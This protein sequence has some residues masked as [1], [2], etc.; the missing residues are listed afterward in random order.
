M[1]VK[2]GAAGASAVSDGCG[3]GNSDV[4]DCACGIAL[5]I[6]VSTIDGVL[7]VE[8]KSIVS[9]VS[10]VAIAMLV[11]TLS[12]ALESVTIAD[13]SSLGVA[14]VD[15]FISESATSLLDAKL[16]GKSAVVR[17]PIELVVRL[18]VPVVFAAVLTLSC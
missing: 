18:E 6:E 12:S 7:S 11:R 9:V 2:A 3:T 8:L 16:A 15:A 13:S 10:L 4:L 17:W 14:I 5:S 1:V